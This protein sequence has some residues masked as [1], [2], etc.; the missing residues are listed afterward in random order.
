MWSVK[1]T[2]PAS[3]QGCHS[4]LSSCLSA[5]Q[6]HQGHLVFWIKQD[7]YLYCKRKHDKRADAFAVQ[8][9]LVSSGSS[10]VVS[11]GTFGTGLVPAVNA[12]HRVDMMAAGQALNTAGQADNTAG[13]SLQALKAAVADMAKLHAVSAGEVNVIGFDCCMHFHTTVL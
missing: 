6:F 2:Q 8:A 11:S 10:S 7:I 9:H 12:W 4:D 1:A 5:G 3:C 13:S